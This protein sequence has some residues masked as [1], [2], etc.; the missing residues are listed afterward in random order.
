MFA[1]SSFSYSGCRFSGFF[2]PHNTWHH[3]ACNNILR[4]KLYWLMAMPPLVKQD[5]LSYNKTEG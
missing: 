1:G 4:V 3:W 2:K 5:L